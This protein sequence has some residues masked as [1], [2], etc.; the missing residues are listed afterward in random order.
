M[1]VTTDS[2]TTMTLPSDREIVLTRTFNAPRTLVWQ[3]WTQPE[4]VSKWWGV[5]GLEITSCTIHLHVGGG[6]RYVLRG[7]DG[8]EYA[9]TG[10][11][12]EVVPPE[13]LVYTDSFEGM[14]DKAAVVTVTFAEQDGKTTLTSRSLYQSASDRDAHIQ[15]GMEAGMRESMDQLAAHL[16]SLH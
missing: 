6:Y 16:Q 5:Q 12:R 11:Y 14:P 2:G 10:V 13:R 9:F 4:H 15:S 1:I 3:A 7:P 8:A